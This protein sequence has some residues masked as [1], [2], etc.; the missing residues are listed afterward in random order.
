MRG[1]KNGKDKNDVQDKRLRSSPYLGYDHDKLG[2]H[3]MSCKA[4]DVAEAQFRRA[5]WLNQFEPC[6]KIHLAWCLYKEK[7]YIEAR[8]WLSE[9][10]ENNI[11]ATMQSIKRLIEE[12]MSE[13]T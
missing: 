6:F 2:V 13:I 3:M 12:G 11:T 4:Y 10:P 9:I 7:K 5:I 1:T 8:K